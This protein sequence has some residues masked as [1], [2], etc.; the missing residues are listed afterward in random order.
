MNARLALLTT[1]ALLAACSGPTGPLPAT[2]QPI[3]RGTQPKVMW[4][5]KAGDGEN[6]VFSPAFVDGA[7]YAAARNGTVKVKDLAAQA[8]S[9]VPLGELAAHV[10]QLLDMKAH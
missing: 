2:L 1:A 3:E 9:D 4:S 6:Y 5:A 7:V 8:E 10:K